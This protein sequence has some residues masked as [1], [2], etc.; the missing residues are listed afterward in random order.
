MG[1]GSLGVLLLWRGT[2]NNYH[3]LENKKNV[4]ICN[5]LFNNEKHE[6]RIDQKKKLEGRRKLTFWLLWAWIGDCSSFKM[7]YIWIYTSQNVWSSLVLN[8]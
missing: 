1:H 4:C 3:V 7:N 6:T 5:N 2:S 8:S